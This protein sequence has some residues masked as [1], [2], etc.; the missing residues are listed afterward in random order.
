MTRNISVYIS[1]SSWVHNLIIIL[2]ENYM[3]NY[4][5]QVVQ[6]IDSFQPWL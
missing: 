1:D 5:P 2:L 4:V 6:E 3:Y